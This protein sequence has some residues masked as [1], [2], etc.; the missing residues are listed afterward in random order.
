MPIIKNKYNVTKS[1]IKDRFKIPN[2]VEYMKEQLTIIPKSF[3]NDEESFPMIL[4]K[5][6]GDVFEIPYKWGKDTFGSDCEQDIS[7]GS[8]ID[9]ELQDWVTIRPEQIKILK[10]LWYTLKI[11]NRVL[12]DA[13]PGTG[14]TVMGIMTAAKIKR[15]FAIVVGRAMLIDQWRESILKFTNLKPNDIGLVKADVYDVE[16]KKCVL[17]ST[18]SFYNREFDESFLRYFGVVMYD[19]CFT[20]DV[21]ILTEKGFTRFDKLDK[22]LKVAQYD[23]GNISFVNPLRHIENNYAGEIINFTGQLEA[24]CTPNHEMLIHRMPNKTGA[25]NTTKVKAI[26]LKLNTITRIYNCGNTITESSNNELTNFEKLMIVLQADGHIYCNKTVQHLENNKVQLHFKFKKLNKI[27]KFLELKE[28]GEFDI[29]EVS[30]GRVGYRSFTI[31]GFRK[32]EVSKRLSDW[33]D[34]S[35]LSIEKCKAIIEYMVLWDGSI[36]DENRYYYSSTVEENVDFYQSVAILAGYATNKT[37]QVDNRSDNYS[38][39]YRL[40]IRKDVSSFTTGSVKKEIIN[41]EGKVYC[42]TVPSGNILIRKNGKVSVVGNC[43]N[44]YSQQKFKALERFYAK[45]QIG[46]SA[47][48]DRRDGRDKVSKLCFGDIQVRATGV[49]PVPITVK[50]I[51]IFHEQPLQ[52]NYPYFF[53]NNIYPRWAEITKLSNLKFR[54]DILLKYIYNEYVD[55]RYILC[56]SDRIEQLQYIYECLID[57]GAKEDE[58]G[59]AARTAYTGDYKVSLTINVEAIDNYK[60]R[61]KAFSNKPEYANLKYTIG[62]TRISARGFSKKSDINLFIDHC[63]TILTDVSNV[64]SKGVEKGKITLSDDEIKNILNDKKYKI[65]FSTYN[66]LRE[67]V[68]IWWMSRLFD[69]TPQGRAEQLLGRI[70]RQAEDG[71]TKDAPI[72]YTVIDSGNIS[73]RILSL[74]RNRLANYN[75]LSYVTVEKG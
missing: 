68:S 75:N 32:T 47:T 6:K 18:D 14:K 35:E 57:K 15:T 34:I 11:D 46:I 1:E 37:V 26:D 49:N 4:Y 70:G 55:N 3:S 29:S 74:H 19:E 60:D 12:L 45:Y 67:G 8:S 10:D 36:T 30:S 9:I 64:I 13:P 27:N 63:R 72:A 31:K 28:C 17:I 73:D 2:A 50:T 52:V 51:P 71:L 39:V 21:E 16:N 54:N 38:D 56:V 20:G 59:F 23:N 25:I 65:I 66:L 69:L 41:Y 53:A 48:H 24:S 40:F 42:V 43:H 22:S 5:Q 33:F 44:F 7:L 58:L 61:I 62:K